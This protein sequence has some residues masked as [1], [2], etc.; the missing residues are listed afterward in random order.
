MVFSS[1]VF[2]FGLLPVTI[3][4]YYVLLRN[5]R[6]MQNIFLLIV[7]IFFYAWGEPLFVLILFL[8][9]VISW[10]CG[11]MIDKNKGNN[12]RKLWLIFGII[13]NVLILFVFKYLNFFADNFSKLLKISNS[14]PLIG[15]PIGISFFTFQ[16]L[17]Y[18]ID[19]YREKKPSQ[20][21]PLFVGL[22]IAFFPQ[23]IAGP[24]VRY[25][26]IADQIQNRKESYE[27]FSNGIFRFI[28]G[29]GK[30]VVLA[31]S[32]AIIA[33]SA[34]SMASPGF[35]FAW[36]GA[37][38]YS[39]QI[40]FDFS[41]YSDMAI[42]LGKMFGF[43]FEEN[44]NKP[45]LATS[46]SDFWRRWHISMGTWFRDYVYF[47]LGGSRVKKPRMVLNLFIVWLLTGIWHGSNW[48]FIL[49][50]VL[51]FVF[52][53]IEKLTGLDKKHINKFIGS[54]YTLLLV[55]L[56]WVLFR[57]DSISYAFRYL[58]SMVSVSGEGWALTLIYMKENWVI[59]I[60]GIVACLPVFEVIN[61]LIKSNNLKLI[62]KTVF[63]VFVFIISITF[64]IK[65]TYNPFIYFNF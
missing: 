64:V 10:L 11:I 58:K 63:T 45:Y 33:D 9:I 1:S 2:L 51:Y 42:G 12:I 21:S 56:G 23:L 52:I 49:W 47:P 22:Y 28:I 8:S 54:F 16:A 13:F 3:V 50:G 35:S 65:G 17:S 25:E 19:V 48:T 34:F 29:L 38:A 6:L 53:C 5:S 40:L 24:I 30:K 31:N 41:G 61:R 55:M 14:I 57:S 46:I 36:L 39:L 60:I 43:T 20:K 32:F 18:I 26:T 27:L 15:L 59:I 44:F 62:L 7:S 37:I 4:L